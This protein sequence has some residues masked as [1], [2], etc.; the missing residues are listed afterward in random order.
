MTGA[1]AQDTEGWPDWLIEA[2]AVES[3]ELKTMQLKIDAGPYTFTLPKG[4]TGPNEFEGGWFFESQISEVATLECY[5][6]TGDNDLATLIGN[7]T[8]LNIEATAEANGGTADNRNVF[9]LDAG[10]LGGAPYL[11]IEW[12][13]TIGEAPNA[14]VALSKMRVAS[15][16]TMTQACSH[17]EV[18]YRETFEQIFAEFVLSAKEPKPAVEPYYAEVLLQMLDGQ[19][20]G[21]S[22]AKYTLDQDGDTKVETTSASLMPTGPDTIAG[23]DSAGVTWSTPEGKVI[24]ASSTSAEN[25]EQVTSLQLMRNE[26]SNWQVSGTFQGK[27]LNET[28]DGS[29]EPVSEVGEMQ[30]A[31]QLFAGDDTSVTY[32][33]WVTDADPTQMLDGTITRDDADTAGQAVLT[34]GPLS[35]QGQFDDTGALVRAGMQMGASELVIEQVWHEGEPH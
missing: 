10:H 18:G 32:P 7:L 26:E 4:T 22:K 14:A 30:I 29:I 2:M 6:F 19:A 24:S 21:Y 1:H 17:N 15:N 5:V 16:G 28:I 3:E 20:I 31:R 25:G 11:A 12:L 34:L 35:L 8:E 27:E 23:S 13:Y 33:V 9:A